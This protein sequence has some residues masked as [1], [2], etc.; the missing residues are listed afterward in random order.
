MER[1]NINMKIT[2]KEII[3]LA[4]KVNDY[5]ENHKNKSPNL[6]GFAEVSKALYDESNY[7][8]LN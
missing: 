8:V 7:Y 2:N 6:R 5:L 1:Q 4:N 3:A